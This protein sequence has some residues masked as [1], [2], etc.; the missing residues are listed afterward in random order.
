MTH[1][2]D[3]AIDHSPRSIATAMVRGLKARC[4]CCGSGAMFTGYLKVSDNCA[5]C[6][7]DLSHQRADDFPPY[8]TIMV[9]GHIVVALVLMVERS[10]DWSTGTHLAV[11]IPL[12]IILSMLLLQPL[13][14][15]VV[16]LQ[17]ALRMHGFGDELAQK[18]GEP[19]RLEL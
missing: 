19:D 3:A 8:L 1:P 11:W 12:T 13:K 7:T 18:T 15:A 9:V 5:V 17:W 6:N 4:P 14:G 16:G 2:D 10:T